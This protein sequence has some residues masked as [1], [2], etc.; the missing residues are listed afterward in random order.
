MGLIELVAPRVEVGAVRIAGL[1]ALIA[2]ALA[3]SAVIETGNYYGLGSVVFLGIAGA[4]FLITPAHKVLG[5]HG[6]LTKIV[7]FTLLSLAA[8]SWFAG[9]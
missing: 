4:L 5:F 2:G 7:Y 1:A 9:V 6:I 8:I 3:L